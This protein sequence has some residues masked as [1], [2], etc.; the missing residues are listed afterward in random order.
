M[1]HKYE[2]VY[3]IEFLEIELFDNLAV[4]KHLKNASLNL[5]VIHTTTWT[6]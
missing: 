3:K 2:Y 5:I 4:F 1:A 6:I